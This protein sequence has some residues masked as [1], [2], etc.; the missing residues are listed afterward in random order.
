MDAPTSRRVCGFISQGNSQQIL[1][2]SRSRH[3]DLS[4]LSCTILLCQ[5][6]F[7]KLQFS[8]LQNAALLPKQIPLI[9]LQNGTPYGRG[10]APTWQHQGLL[11]PVGCMD[12]HSGQTSPWKCC[13][14]IL[15]SFQC[16]Y[17]AFSVHGLLFPRAALVH[18]C[19][20]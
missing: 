6:M 14:S 2:L 5:F 4:S 17:W 1:A 20:G 16:G 19:T 7:D 18:A 8:F 3:A 13:A 11:M 15:G 12:G 9:C 10:H